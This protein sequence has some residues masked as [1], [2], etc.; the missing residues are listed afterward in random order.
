MKKAILTVHCVNGYSEEAEKCIAPIRRAL[1][2][3][4]PDC[5]CYDAYLSTGRTRISGR[6]NREG[7]FCAGMLESLEKDG[8]G[9]ICISPLL[10]VPGIYY[11]AVREI[12]PNCPVSRPLLD[13]DGDF[14]RIA[15]IYDE[16]ARKEGRD[17]LLMGH[18]S[19]G[20]GDEIY[21]RLSDRLGAHVHLA[22]ARGIMSLEEVLPYI[23]TGRLLL[24]PLMLTA[25]SHARR[26]MD[27]DG[28]QSW[29][30][31]L[32]NRGF[33][34]D[35]RL[36]GMGSMPAVQEMFVRKARKAFGD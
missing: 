13:D 21:A 18:G 23:E 24:M 36:E 22:C 28:P 2:N 15:D 30:N 16:I 25:G 8:C 1:G 17:V 4:F 26:E 27:G 32:M 29:K 33:D 12:A 10:L 20:M 14:E 34:V 35:V 7:A 19:T 9:Q 11:N 31:I 3:A 6:G 5:V